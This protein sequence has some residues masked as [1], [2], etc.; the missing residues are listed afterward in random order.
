MFRLPD[1]LPEAS[2]PPRPP[3][4]GRRIESLLNGF[5]AAKHDALFIAPDAF[6][7]RKSWDAVDG[8]PAI[9]QRLQEL[10]TASLE[11]AVDDDERAALAARLDL[12]ITDAMGSVR[13]HVASQVA[14]WRREVVD[15]RQRLLKSAT[16]LEYDDDDKVA[17]FAEASAT[18]AAE[19][20]R[21]DGLAP[22]S[23]ETAAAILAARS[24][25]LRGAIDQRIANRKE[26]TALALF[27]RIKDR[28]SPAD[29][30]A[31]EAPMHVAALNTATD[32]W[33]QREA[34]KP[35]MPLGEHAAADPALTPDEKV[36]IAIKVAAEE[37]VRESNRVVTVMGLDDE[38]V[39]ATRALATQPSAYRFGTYAR[40][41]RSYE[42]A[43]ESDKAA[44]MH[45]AAL[46]EPMLH[47][48]A[49]G[50]PARQQGLIAALPELDRTLA[51]N[52][53]SP[54]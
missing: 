18:A 32:A 38:R 48:F 1:W 6:Q 10:R 39:A 8:E 7:R 45:R 2:P 47:A 14:V 22:D 35:G 24:G 31:L 44:D 30:Q 29:R 26:A 13:R 51:Q 42:D 28:L 49:L 21:I 19:R 23:A 17:G 37:T 5:I 36:V 43:G 25:I 54:G 15:E 9:G 53:A 34:G 41:A 3:V 12:Q 40:L 4:D 50:S 16:A 11:Q 46:Q 27:E 20:T 33:L 52:F